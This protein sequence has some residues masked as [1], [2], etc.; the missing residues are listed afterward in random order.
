MVRSV[1]SRRGFVIHE[2]V[3]NYT[4]RLLIFCVLAEPVVIE[5]GNAGSSDH[6]QK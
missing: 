6:S 1:F 5:L 4:R 2:K 3:L